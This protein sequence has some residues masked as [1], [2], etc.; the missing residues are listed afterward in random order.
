M[1]SKSYYDHDHHDSEDECCEKPGPQGPIGPQGPMG[2]MGP[3]GC[4]GWKGHTGPQG[5]VGPTGPQGE[6]GPTGPQGE[7]GPTGPQ[8]LQGEMGPT[9]LQGE[10]GP[11]GYTGYTGYTGIQGE[12]GPTGPTGWTGKCLKSFLRAYNDEPQIVQ[13]NSP[14][15]FNKT[16]L[17]RGPI[18]FVAGTGQVLLEQPG[19]YLILAKV[20]HLF[21]AQAALFLNG[22]VLQGSTIGEAA[23][24]A[25]LIFH[26]I[27]RVTPED[28]LPN[29][30]AIHTGVAA[31]LEVR[32][33]SSYS[34]IELDGRE[35]SG[36]ELDQAN[37][38]IVVV[39]ICD[40]YSEEM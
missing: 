8:G 5:E 26:E 28:L 6:W 21:A 16:D 12:V 11:T 34:P 39:Q 30:N 7:W 37:A 31:I 25:M 40:E 18:Y 2:A 4:H 19:Y 36:T 14:V 35:G 1:S 23:A 29:P 13:V 27:V 33:H 22:N 32:N 24:A 20:F 10:V 3:R 15:N 38:S 9:G 17:I